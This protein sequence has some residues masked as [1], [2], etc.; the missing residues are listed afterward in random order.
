MLWFSIISIALLVLLYVWLC[1]FTPGSIILL[2]SYNLSLGHNLYWKILLYSELS[3][4]VLLKLT[5]KRVLA[6]YF[7][8]RS[9]ITQFP[10]PLSIT[11]VTNWKYPSTFMYIITYYLIIIFFTHV[12][13]LKLPIVEW[14]WL[15][16][17]VV[18]KG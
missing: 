7:L 15:F 18:L 10:C 8:P 16:V 1:I 12:Y 4:C 9:E 6:K 11:F 2:R 13:S 17:W 3:S 14:K 5:V